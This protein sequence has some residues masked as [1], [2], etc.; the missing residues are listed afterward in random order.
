ML[1]LIVG[2]INIGV[3]LFIGMD[4]PVSRADGA[5]QWWVDWGWRTGVTANAVLGVLNVVRG[6]IEIFA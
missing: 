2:M 3:A 5:M 4:K 6:I 1:S